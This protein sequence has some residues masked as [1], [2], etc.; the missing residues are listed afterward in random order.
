MKG[1]A[2]GEVDVTGYM[3]V[4]TWIGRAGKYPKVTALLVAKDNDVRIVYF[5]RDSK[6]LRS[7]PRPNAQTA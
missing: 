5:D 2:R 3:V 7:V 4:G 1:F 6:A